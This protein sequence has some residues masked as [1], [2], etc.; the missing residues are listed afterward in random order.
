[1]NVVGEDTTCFDEEYPPRL[2]VRGSVPHFCLLA[3]K[4]TQKANTHVQL[5]I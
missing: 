3:E 4:E 5:D 1:M 2:H